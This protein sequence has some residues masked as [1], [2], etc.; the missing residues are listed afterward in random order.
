MLLAEQYMKPATNLDTSEGFLELENKIK[1]EWTSPHVKSDR[2][3]L[4][5]FDDNSLLYSNNA[6]TEAYEDWPNLLSETLSRLVHIDLSGIP[7]PTGPEFYFDF[8][9]AVQIEHDKQV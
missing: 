9:D 6:E 3:I 2:S 8:L 5:L 4:I 7:I 1:N